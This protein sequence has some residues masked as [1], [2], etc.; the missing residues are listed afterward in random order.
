MNGF[1]AFFWHETILFFSSFLVT[2][3]ELRNNNRFVGLPRSKIQREEHIER[4]DTANRCNTDRVWQ[5]FNTKG[6]EI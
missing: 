5:M 4:Y 2:I 1:E 6:E 3:D